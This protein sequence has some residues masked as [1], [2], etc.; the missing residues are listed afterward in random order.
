MNLDVEFDR[1][2]RKVAGGPP[3]RR[4]GL[5][6]RVVEDLIEP[7]REGQMF[8]PRDPNNWDMAQ[9]KRV[10][11]EISRRNRETHFL[12]LHAERL[13][14]ERLNADRLKAERLNA[15]PSKFPLDTTSVNWTRPAAD[16]AQGVAETALAKYK[17]GLG[18]RISGFAKAH[19][20]ATGAAI[21]APVLA[22]GGYGAYKYLNKKPKQ[23]GEEEKTSS[24]HMLYPSF[25]EEFSLLTQAHA[26]N[27]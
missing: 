3:L 2:M 5:L 12:T 4:P 10:G 6:D 26:Q 18:E 20:Y 23:Q 25:F 19:P 13:A 21:A 17:P 27:K 14:E 8:D 7:R 22:A 24:L 11:D 1:M 16:A 15:K 9:L